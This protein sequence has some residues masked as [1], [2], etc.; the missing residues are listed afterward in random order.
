[1]LLKT[2]NRLEIGRAGRPPVTRVHFSEANT[3]AKSKWR[4]E[5]T[6]TL[7]KIQGGWGLSRAA[8]RAAE[9]EDYLAR[10]EG[11]PRVG[12]GNCSV[13]QRDVRVSACKTSNSDVNSNEN[14]HNK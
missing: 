2:K 6:C 4:N 14:G 10:T 5:E 9:A 7:Q 8:D 11:F 3:L 12:P 1:M 13:H